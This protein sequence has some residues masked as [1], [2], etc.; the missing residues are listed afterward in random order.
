MAVFERTT[1]VDA[2]L[3]T[4]WAFHSDISGLVALTPDWMRLQIESVTGP[5]GEADPAVLEPGTIIRASVRPLGIGPRQ[6]WVSRIS[7]RERSES[8]GMFRD[9]M[10]SGPFRRWVHTHRLYAEAGGTRIVD[11]VEYRLPLGPF[12]GLSRL[13]WVGLEPLF[14][15]RHRETRARLE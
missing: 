10:L 13:A 12:D 1:W 14:R 7:A 9:V 3:D 4:V 2:S 8:A 6:R 15:Y 5:K 11:H